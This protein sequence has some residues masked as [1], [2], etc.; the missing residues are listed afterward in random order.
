MRLRLLILLMALVL[1]LITQSVQS[2]GMSGS[3]YCVANNAK[4][5]YCIN[6][7]GCPRDGYC[8]FPD[9]GYCDLESFYKGTCPGEEYYEQ[10]I[11]M[12]EANRF[13]SDDF[14]SP[15]IPYGYGYNY[16]WPTYSSQYI[17]YGISPYP[18]SQRAN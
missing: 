16:Y 3:G 4:E 14:Y 12:A 8:Y 6:Q 1:M 18:W 17:P 15:Y 9:G 10:A 13:L 7:G 2:I 11:W 5:A